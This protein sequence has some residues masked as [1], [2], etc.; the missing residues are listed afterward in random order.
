MRVLNDTFLG[1]RAA[2]RLTRNSEYFTFSRYEL[3]GNALSLSFID[4][5]AHSEI[6]GVA[7][8]GNAIT[9]QDS[10]LLL[11]DTEY[12]GLGHSKECW[13]KTAYSPPDVVLA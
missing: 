5:H 12:G 3:V 8:Y 1:K 4:G 13:R 10:D 9:S 7:T 2:D 6:I 11:P